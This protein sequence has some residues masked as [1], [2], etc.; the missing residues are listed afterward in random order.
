ML[1]HFNQLQARFPVWVSSFTSDDKLTQILSITLNT[2]I[3]PVDYSTLAASYRMSTNVMIL[4]PPRSVEVAS[5]ETDV[6]Y[7]SPCSS[8]AS[9]AVWPGR[10]TTTTP[11]VNLSV[12]V[13]AICRARIRL[14]D[15]VCI[16][17]CCISYLCT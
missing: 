5:S 15:L 4:T 13:Q 11:A 10:I 12:A 8:T 17:V 16:L 7:F 1:L 6:T 9:C 14:C 2:M 3:R